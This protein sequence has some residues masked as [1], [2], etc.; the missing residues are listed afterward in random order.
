MCFNQ[1]ALGWLARMAFACEWAHSTFWRRPDTE[2]GPAK[3]G[4]PPG[5]PRNEANG[6]NAGERERNGT[7]IMAEREPL[8]TMNSVPF[9][10]FN[11]NS[12]IVEKLSPVKSKPETAF[13]PYS[14]PCSHP[15]TA[16]EAVF[17]WLWSL[18]LRLSLLLVWLPS[19]P[20]RHLH[21]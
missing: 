5:G 4:V 6:G 3:R 10:P 1:I 15:R 16:F 13:P 11:T 7:E 14:F 9:W 12:L 2:R 17:L 19:F 21:G 20:I 18:Q 8:S